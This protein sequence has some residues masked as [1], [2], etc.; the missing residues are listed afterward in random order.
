MFWTLVIAQ[1]IIS[2]L[3]CGII[4]GSKNRDVSVWVLMG[5]LFGLFA[6]IAAV[7]VTPLA[8]VSR[9]VPMLDENSPDEA[10]S[11]PNVPFE[12]DRILTS[13]GYRLWLA[14]RYGIKRNEL[15]NSFV[16]GDRMFP[17]LEQALVHAHSQEM[18]IIAASE[19]AAIAKAEAEEQERQLREQRLAQAVVKSI[20]DRRSFWRGEAWI[21]AALVLAAAGG[22]LALIQYQNHQPQNIEGR[23]SFDIAGVKK[24]LE[25]Y[26]LPLLD[27]SVSYKLTEDAQVSCYEWKDKN[28]V[29]VTFSTRTVSGYVTYLYDEA[30]REAGYKNVTALYPD[31]YQHSDGRAFKVKAERKS[32]RT[33]VTLCLVEGPGAIK[34]VGEAG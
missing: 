29:A 21:V 33:D 34:A 28:P 16:V 13:D 11:A 5:F 20:E 6:L 4:A 2:A 30:A 19:A 7:G 14:D 9:S 1:A 26:E 32:S 3:L 10:G 24:I 8:K 22:L 31:A 27:D 12:G 17:E 25:T 23:Q 18:E 15:F